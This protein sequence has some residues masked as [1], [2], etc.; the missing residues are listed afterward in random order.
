MAK[1][2]KAAST[3][4]LGSPEP[5]FRASKPLVSQLGMFGTAAQLNAARQHAELVKTKAFEQRPDATAY[6]KAP[7]NIEPI[8][9]TPKA[10]M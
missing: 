6:S 1:L 9:A 3:T 2:L 10:G 8:A 7:L 5:V 4:P